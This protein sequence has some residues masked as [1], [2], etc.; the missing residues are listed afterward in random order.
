MIPPSRCHPHDGPLMMPRS[1]SRLVSSRLLSSR[2][3]SSPLLSSHPLVSSPP[4]LSAPLLLSSRLLLSSSR[5]VSSPLSSSPLLLSSRLLLSSSRL[6]SSPLSSS[7]PHSGPHTLEVEPAKEEASAT[8]RWS[9]YSCPWHILRRILINPKKKPY[10]GTDIVIVLAIDRHCYSVLT[11]QCIDKTSQV[12]QISPSSLCRLL[13]WCAP[14]G[15]WPPNTGLRRRPIGNGRISR[16]PSSCRWCGV[17]Y[18]P[19][20]PGGVGSAAGG[21]QVFICGAFSIGTDWPACG[22]Y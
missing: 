19:G 3:V 6:V 13:V 11:V 18:V 20:G 5:L 14:K 1:S 17:P 12:A 2:L 22:V 15:T 16:F 8:A 7:L 4:L 10:D 9:T 21:P